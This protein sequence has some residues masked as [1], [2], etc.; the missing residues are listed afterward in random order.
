MNNQRLTIIYRFL[1]LYPNIIIDNNF[2]KY[3]KD[4]I[5]IN[6][7]DMTIF[8]NSLFLIRINNNT[9][10]EEDF[11]N[12]LKLASLNIEDDEKITINNISNTT[13]INMALNNITN[14]FDVL[15]INNYQK[16][17]LRNINSYSNK[18]LSMYEKTKEFIAL[19]QR[20]PDFLNDKEKSWI[21]K[22]IL[23]KEK[24]PAQTS[25]NKGIISAL[26]V[27]VVIMFSGFLIGVL[28]YFCL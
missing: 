9:L 11:F 3:N 17:L 14:D 1:H 24:V 19:A 23:P 7:I 16:L 15:S 27:T 8:N 12:I 22:V 2:L 21:S 26:L 25:D 20:Y 18:E 6:D 28:T 10:T 13:L 4:N 5:N